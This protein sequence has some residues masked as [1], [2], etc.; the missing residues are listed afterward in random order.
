MRRAGA[1]RVVRIVLGARTRGAEQR[2][3]ELLVPGEEPI[4][5]GIVPASVRA[6]VRGTG[7]AGGANV[8]VPAAWS[9]A[10]SRPLCPYPQVARY[11]GSGSVELAENFECR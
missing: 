2:P 1:A 9:T 3:G 8:D 11:K 7:N 4:E 10:R 6:Q 5:R